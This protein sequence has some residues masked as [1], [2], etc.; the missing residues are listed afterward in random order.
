MYVLEV[1]PLTTLPPQIPQILSYY[2]DSGLPK[3]AIVEISLNNRLVTATV[4]DSY[5]LDEQKILI[6]NLFFNS[7]ISRVLSEN[8]L[9]PN[10]NLKSLCG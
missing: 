1:L 4:I 2:H 9:L 8:P 7:K 6:K 10:G 5:N 3:G